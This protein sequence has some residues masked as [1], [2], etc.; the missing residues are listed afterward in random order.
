MRIITSNEPTIDVPAATEIRPLRNTD[1]IPAK[2]KSSAP[3]VTSI[4]AV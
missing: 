1:S 4:N 2:V 3:I